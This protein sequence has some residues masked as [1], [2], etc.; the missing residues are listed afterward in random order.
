MKNFNKSFIAA[1]LIMCW[2]TIFA[3]EWKFNDGGNYKRV[4]ENSNPALN[5]QI[6][7]REFSQWA[8]EDDRGWFLTMQ[9]GGRVVVP[10]TS[11]LEFNDGFYLSCRFMVD[12]SKITK[13]QFANLVTKGDNYDQGYS[14]MVHRDGRLLIYLK[15]IT[16]A[17]ALRS[18]V[19]IN[20]MREYKLEIFAGKGEV[21]TY[22][23]G[24]EVDRY[25]YTGNFNF[26]NDKPLRIGQMGGYAFTG[27]FYNLI[28][29]PYKEPVKIENTNKKTKIIL[30]NPEGTVWVNDFTKFKEQE[31]IQIVN[32]PGTEKNW[33]I[34]FKKFFPKDG[35]QVLHPPKD[36]NIGSIS[37]NPELK[38]N[39]DI[40]IGMRITGEYSSIKFNL[41]D[42]NHAIIVRTL[43]A[44]GQNHF[45]HEVPLFK[46]VKMD[47]LSLSLSPTGENAYIGYIKFV[48][49]G[50]RKIEPPTEEK[51][52]IFQGKDIEKFDN[53]RNA[54]I[55]KLINSGYFA[56]RHYIDKTP[57][58]EISKKSQER[59]FIVDINDYMQLTFDNSI[60]KK[61]D[62]SAKITTK[63]AKGEFENA[64]FSIFALNDLKNITFNWKKTF[65][66]GIDADIFAVKAVPKRI[67][68][69]VGSGEF[70]NA[71]QYLEAFTTAAL[72]KNSNLPCQIVIH[73]AKEVKAG[74]YHAEL[75][76]N[77][78]NKKY[79]LPIEVIV[80]NFTLDLPLGYD[81]SFWIGFDGKTDAEIEAEIKSL[82]EHNFT[83]LVVM[84]SINFKNNEAGN[85]V[86]D[87]EK[88]P[89]VTAVKY[90]KK[91]NLPGRLHIGTTEIY[92]AN[93]NNYKELITSL[94]DYA[95]KNNWPARVYTCY[96]EVSSHPE[97]FPALTARLQDLKD[98][99]LTT[100]VDHIYYKT[101]RPIQKEIDKMSHLVDVFVLRYNTRG[102]FYADKWDE[103]EKTITA[104]GKELIAYNSNNGLLFTQPAMMRFANGWF[105]RSFGKNTKGQ[106]T[107]A[108]NWY[109]GTPYTDLDGS[110]DWVYIFPAR[111][112]KK[113]GNSL[114]YE[115][116]REGID[117]LRYIITL[118]NLIAEARNKNL[119]AQADNAQ[120]L[121][122][123]IAGS[124]DKKTFE[125]KSVFIDS[126]FEEYGTDARG[127]LFASGDFTVPNGWANS[128]YGKAREKVANM[129]QKLTEIIKEQR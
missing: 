14:I 7:Q 85:K 54:E 2:G 99:N 16:P 103:I 37:Y 24:E 61:D 86:I 43:K 120:K 40:Y 4:K 59:G 117:D 95:N 73:A 28:L 6:Y 69:Y 51:I 8:R 87:F 34:R 121:L 68:N 33:S 52:Q 41:S 79:L 5:G 107:W 75:E 112:N 25:K 97:Q 62:N 65:P 123:D 77:A 19:K 115:L 17:Y 89:I 100:H 60:P 36:I 128:D 98:M 29:E 127:Q 55:Q 18:R 126:K 129:I 32:G 101:T 21:I 125:A 104:K 116:M 124:F 22:L 45:N 39:Y 71:P 74:T 106:F 81:L 64:A 82:A 49:A 48:P 111:G 35:L 91:Y 27:A 118:E 50:T 63:L 122:N 78:D 70:I 12:L 102:I 108:W 72:Q 53:I 119:T 13:S 105:F 109:S 38:G 84:N 15:G 46:N 58:P 1:V 42:N 3:F 30:D 47:D 92:E 67:N 11:E 88:S 76:I 83:S 26:S 57:M 93:P 80:R 56:E 10:N 94:E 113:G 110:V 66:K 31:K 44:D 23:D 9:N 96:D 20:S 114:N 90:M